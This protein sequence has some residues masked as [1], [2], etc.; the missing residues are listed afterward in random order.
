L[1]AVQREAARVIT[2]MVKS[3]PGEAVLEEAG[4]R[5]L[6]VVAR[7]KWRV[8]FEKCLRVRE[9]N[10][11][12][13]LVRRRVRQ[14]LKKRGWRSQTEEMMAEYEE[15]VGVSPSEGCYQE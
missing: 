11:R 7:G 8:E 12:G 14:R 5:E 9:D 6:E 4:L 13:D 15:V 1:E 2:G 3:S 10:P